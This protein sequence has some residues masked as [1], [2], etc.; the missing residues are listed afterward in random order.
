MKTRNF[1]LSTLLGLVAFTGVAQANSQDPLIFTSQPDVPASIPTNGPVTCYPY[2]IKN[3]LTTDSLPLDIALVP[4]DDARISINYAPVP[5]C[6]AETDCGDTLGKGKSCTI[7]VKVDPSQDP[8][9][10]KANETLTIEYSPRYGALESNPP[11]IIDFVLP[12]PAVLK[13]SDLPDPPANVIVGDAAVEFTYT[14]ENIGE[15]D[16]TDIVPTI[17]QRLPANCSPSLVN[18]VSSTCGMSQPY[19]LAPGATCDITLDVEALTTTPLDCDIDV[20]NEYT[21]QIGYV[22]VGAPLESNIDFY[23]VQPDAFLNFEEFPDNLPPVVILGTVSDEFTFKIKNYGSATATIGSITNITNPL[24]ANPL[25]VAGTPL[26][27]ACGATLNAGASCTLTYVLDATSTT[28]TPDI[29]NYTNILAIPYD[30]TDTS[31][32]Q[33][34]YAFAVAEAASILSLDCDPLTDIQISTLNVPVAGTQT[35]SCTLTNSGNADAANLNP[36]FD[37]D[38]GF[39][40]LTSTTCPSAG[41]NFTLPA[42]NSCTL[43]YTIAP[44]V[45]G[46]S[47]Q[48]LE[49]VYEATPGNFA[50]V[51][52]AVDF[53]VYTAKPNDAYIVYSDVSN[54]FVREYPINTDGS[55]ASPSSAVSVSGVSSVDFASTTYAYTSAYVNFFNDKV[56]RCNA[57]VF[58]GCITTSSALDSP[59]AAFYGS[60]IKFY[61]PTLAYLSN[62]LLAPLIPQP[63]NDV[64]LCNVNPGTNG[65]SCSNALGSDI[66]GPTALGL[67]KFNSTDHFAYILNKTTDSLLL[68]TINAGVGTFSSCVDSGTADIFF[69]SGTLDFIS[70]GELY[71][72]VPLQVTNNQVDIMRCQINGNPSLGTLSGCTSVKS[73]SS[74][75]LAVVVSGLKVISLGNTS[76][77]DHPVAYVGYTDGSTNNI[78]A[79]DITPTGGFGSCTSPIPVNAPIQGINAL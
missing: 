79:C 53:Y 62:F 44:V 33:T 68:C 29:R 75:S 59:N 65:F 72:Y 66:P 56:K 70:A 23:V 64:Q 5:G 25:V 35:L 24:P 52:S 41:I 6:M 13:F 38:Y 26:M 11:I 32:L 76:P 73:I 17:V 47:S 58:G 8:T 48:D 1:I 30:N 60:F 46:T 16:A 50:T 34:E 51:A 3:T 57:S 54:G 43:D 77:N 12:P 20:Q 67:L 71:V 36:T 78:I 42:G 4:N 39:I 45:V 15:Q 69:L 14:I 22:G 19:T 49:I 31:P 2:V 27:D 37:M 28:P 10:S 40:S 21:L 55:L 61:T 7:I 74:S 63:N 9:A 18:F